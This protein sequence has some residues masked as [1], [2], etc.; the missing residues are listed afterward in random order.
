METGWNQYWWL[1]N[2]E[3]LNV[4]FA[5][6]KVVNFTL[7]EFY[8][9]KILEEQTSVG[10]ISTWCSPASGHQVP[11]P[12]CAPTSGQLLVYAACRCVRTPT[13]GRGPAPS[14][15]ESPA[16][17]KGRVPGSINILSSRAEP[18]PPA[19]GRAGQ[20]C[21]FKK[22]LFYLSQPANTSS[23]KGVEREK[24][25]SFPPLWPPK[26]LPRINSWLSII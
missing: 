15:G 13:A 4:H 21:S 24:S 5:M 14:T 6:V 9:T 18:Y 22:Y 7:H 20:T 26:P 1:H 2:T 23:K 8:L 25:V 17:H 12:S 16:P 11:F 10:G 19:K 3:P